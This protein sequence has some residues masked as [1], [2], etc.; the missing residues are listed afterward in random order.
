MV[1]IK[2]RT[3]SRD[4]L[5]LHKVRYTEVPYAKKTKIWLTSSSIRYRVGAALWSATW[6][7]RYLIRVSATLPNF[8][9][10]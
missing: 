10:H 5:T 4:G 2:L 1:V 8:L 6:I 7:I 3:K 9:L